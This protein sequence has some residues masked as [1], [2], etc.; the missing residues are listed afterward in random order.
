MEWTLKNVEKFSSF[1]W[2]DEKNAGSTCLEGE[3]ICGG[4]IEVE[5]LR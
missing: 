4:N 3:A 2:I 1:G 5:I